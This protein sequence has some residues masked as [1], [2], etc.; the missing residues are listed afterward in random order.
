MSPCW[1]QSKPE[2]T[3]R[4][5]EMRLPLSLLP[6]GDRSFDL[7]TIGLNS[8]DLVAQVATYPSRDTKQPL[9]GFAQLPGGEMATAAAAC[10]RLGWRARYVGTF[11]DDAFAEAGLR[12]LTGAGVDVSAAWNVPGTSSRFA[13]VI[14][15]AGTGERTVLWSRDP[16]L[17]IAPAQLSRDVVTSGRVLLVDSQDTEAAIHAAREARAADVRTV[18]DVDHVGAGI[19]ELLRQVDV[20]IAAE[21]LP[22]ALTG[23]AT[24]GRALSAMASECGAALVAVTLGDEGS[25]ALC[26]GREVRTPAFP[27]SCVDSTGAGDAFHAG[28]VAGWLLRPEADVEW[29]MVYANAVAAL[30]CRGL[31]ARGG[32][33]TRDEVDVLMATRSP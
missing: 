9:A 11:G 28:F 30:N 33:P 14:I 16:K 29:L 8:I 15:D 7:V 26:D 1:R 13:I 27:I 10:A 25:L 3:V 20:V 2:Q 18:V 19:D 31:G 12:S 32:L 21:S 5:P 22:E 17:A 4:S 24:P 23:H 6:P